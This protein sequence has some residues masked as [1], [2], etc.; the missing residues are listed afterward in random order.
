MN[1]AGSVA[2]SYHRYTEPMALLG[3]IFLAISIPAVIGLRQL[4]HRFNSTE[5]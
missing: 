1:Q 3:V 4:E 5:R 2:N